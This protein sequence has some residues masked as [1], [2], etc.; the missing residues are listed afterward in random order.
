M[1]RIE[2]LPHDELQAETERVR[3][4]AVDARNADMHQFRGE[5][6]RVW[7]KLAAGVDVP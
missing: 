7:K 2:S 3:Q 6:A 1:A 5:L 4:E